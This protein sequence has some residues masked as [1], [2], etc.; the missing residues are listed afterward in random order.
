VKGSEHSDDLGI[1]G[2]MILKWILRAGLN[3]SDALKTNFGEGQTPFCNSVREKDSYIISDHTHDVSNRLSSFSNDASV[4]VTYVR[5]YHTIYWEE[6]V[7][8]KKN[9]RTAGL[10]ADN[11]R[12]LQNTKQKC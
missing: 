7:K 11:R 10:W 5:Y 4:P 3:Q 9:L 2:R 8:T 1:D 6:H 12:R